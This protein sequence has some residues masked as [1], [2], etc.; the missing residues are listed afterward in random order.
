[1]ASSSSTQTSSSADP[2]TFTTMDKEVE[3]IGAHCQYT[4]CNQLDFLPFR[5]ESCKATYCL[6]HRTE[7]AHRCPHAGAWATARRKENASTASGRPGKPSL[8]TATQCS[9]PACKTYINTL[10]HV[11]VACTICNRQYCLKHRLREDHACTTLIPIGARPASR[12]HT[13]NAEKARAAFGRL[14]AWGKEKQSAVLP[15][16]KAA[17]NAG[18]I[19]ALN[20]LK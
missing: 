20:Q 11:A 10:T 4:Y 12:P 7:T 13:P 3:A 15:K 14:R 2:P 18:R 17:S 6:D 5:C 19:A 8:L 9:H 1:M 16:P